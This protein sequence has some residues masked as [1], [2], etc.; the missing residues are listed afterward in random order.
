MADGLE[1][2][3]NDVVMEW[4]DSNIIQSKTSDVEEDSVID[5]SC[6]SKLV[7]FDNGN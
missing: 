1:L 5:Y 4:V 2:N 6:N 7:T 3:D